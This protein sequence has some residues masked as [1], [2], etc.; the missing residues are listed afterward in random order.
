MSLGEEETAVEKGEMGR[1]HN[2]TRTYRASVG[3][4]RA[5]V[6]ATNVGDAR[7]LVKMTAVSDDLLGKCLKEFAR[8]E[9]RLRV[10][11]DRP[12]DGEREIGLS[13]EL[14]RDTG[15]PHRLDLTPKIAQPSLVL[16]VNEVCRAFP[17]AVDPVLGNELFEPLDCPLV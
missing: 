17:V 15:A 1:K 16:C 11:P 13:R 10:D 14:C 7:V 9:L 5:L 8:M 6:A 4:H 2:V 3:Y 12:Q